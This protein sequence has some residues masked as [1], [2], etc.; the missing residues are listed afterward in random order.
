MSELTPMSKDLEA[1]AV[2]ILLNRGANINFVDHTNQR[3][4]LHVAALTDYGG[5]VRFLVE[6]GASITAVNRQCHT[7]LSL[8]L[9]AQAKRV[10]GGAR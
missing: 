9:C 1:E 3:L 8:A 4:A 10:C 7:P 2:R 6:R 5:L